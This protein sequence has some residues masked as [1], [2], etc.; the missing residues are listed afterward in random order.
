[1][2][3][4]SDSAADAIRQIVTTSGAPDGSGLRIAP[5]RDDSSLRLSLAARPHPGDVVYRTGEA[6]VFLEAAANKVL[7][8]QTIEA[9][10]A[11]DGSGGVQFVVGPGPR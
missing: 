1:M 9:A 2:F 10:P 6:Q 11:D 4:V 3:T 8:G 7:D 5:A